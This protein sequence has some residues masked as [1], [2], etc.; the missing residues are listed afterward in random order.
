L[1]DSGLQSVSEGL[2]ALR[3]RLG[4][5]RSAPS[6]ALALEVAACLLFVEWVLRRRGGLLSG[7]EA[8]CAEIRAR[9]DPLPANVI[10]LPE[11]PQWLRDLARFDQE[12]S[13]QAALEQALRASLRGCEQ[14]LEAFFKQPGQNEGLSAVVGLLM[15]SAGVLRVLGRDQ[16][17]NELLALAQ[18]VQRCLLD[19]A[20]PDALVQEQMVARLSGLSLGTMSPMSPMSRQV[21]GSEVQSRLGELRELSRQDASLQQVFVLEARR[22]LDEIATV[23]ASVPSSDP[24]APGDTARSESLVGGWVDELLRRVHTLRGS[25]ST[26]GAIAFES[27]LLDMETRLDAARRLGKET[28][29]PERGA[30][31]AAL[32]ADLAQLRSHALL[33][34]SST[35]LRDAAWPAA[36]SAA[37]SPGLESGKL[38]SQH[39]SL[40]AD[41]LHRVVRQAS[42]DAGRPALLVIEGEHTP[43]TSD[44]MARLP[45]LLGHLLRNALAHGIEEAEVRQACGKPARGLIL[46]RLSRTLD[47]LCLELSDDGRGPDLERIRERAKQMG[48]SPENDPAALMQLMFHPGL[49]TADDISALAGRGVGLDAARAQV[50]AMG[51]QIALSVPPGRGLRIAIRL[52]DGRAPVSSA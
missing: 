25:A 13:T 40:L 15:Q 36:P 51:G 50:L 52:P 37:S 42:R 41:R 2:L 45:D 17:A 9:L 8:R 33:Q 14:V 4:E 22:L 35:T 48:L 49:S 21:Q 10:A 24:D 11:W 3:R 30:L 46:L 39:F 1:P 31:L 34:S 26:A 27:I 29:S 19:E 47:A 16:T 43:L 20:P 28:S 44:Q 12:A 32:H 5:S 7:L 6:E 18:G 23:L 38:R